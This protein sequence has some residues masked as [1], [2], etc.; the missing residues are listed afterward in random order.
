MSSWPFP[1]IEPR[2]VQIEALAKG[3]GKQG[4]AYFLR[5][6]LGKTFIACAEFAKLQQDGLADWFLVICPNS[7]KEQWREQIEIADPFMP[8]CIYRSQSK[9]T[10]DY[11]FSKNK[12]GGALII[13]YESVDAFMKELYWQ[14]FDTIKTYVVADESTKLKEP[15]NKLTKACVEL[16][17]LCSFRRVLTG[18]PIA[19]S[20]ADMWGQLKFI[21]AT[22]RNFYQHKYYFTIMGGF[23]GRTI[24]D[25]VNTHILQREIEPHSYIAPDKYIK[26]F[27]K[28]Y[29]PLRRVELTNDLRTLYREME[30]ALL[31]E[32]SEGLEITAPIALTKY[33]RLQQI[34]SGIAGDPDGVQHNLIEPARNPKIKAVLGILEDEISNKCIIVCRFKRSIDNL[35][36]VLTDNGYKCAI[37]R[38]GMGKEL[39]EEKKRFTDG[40]CNILIAQEQVLNFGHTL[41][42]PDDNPCDSM[43]FYENSFS[44]INRAQCESR[45][46]KYQREMPISYYDL[47]SSKMDRY[48]LEALIKKEDASLA[49]MNYQRSSGILNNTNFNQDDAA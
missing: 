41:H 25:N 28:V 13:N 23:Q 44:L 14:K 33:L 38:G 1:H 6:R 35:L 34:S 24:V 42:G 36:E 18:K 48:I 47:Y 19:N 9:K 49:L 31:F 5:Q 32:L 12:K 15:G 27:E 11:F 21:N 17:Q 26:G 2:Q 40:D 46:E 45:P 3:Y 10:V 39:E 29:E 37:M 20:N 43:I 8:I 4:F 16:A 30:T 22:S 7:L